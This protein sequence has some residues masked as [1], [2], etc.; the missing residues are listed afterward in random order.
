MSGEESKTNYFNLADGQFCHLL[1]DKIVITPK[2][3]IVELPRQKDGP[4]AGALILFSILGL[5]AAVLTVCFFW[6]GFYPLAVMT[7][8]ASV[9]SVI[10]FMRSGKFSATN[11]IPRD[12]ITSVTYHRVN[13]G[14]DYF[15]VRYTGTGGRS[16]LRRLTVYDSAEIA[17]KA[18]RLMKAE[19]LLKQ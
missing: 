2:L 18:V 12:A 17:E 19:G 7:L 9:A 16:Y 11:L 5:G 8:I 3:T 13:Y 15:L 14:Y 6:V 10:A 4:S 1:P